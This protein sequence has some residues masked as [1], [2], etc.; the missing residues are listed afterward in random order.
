MLNVPTTTQ[1][2]LLNRNV[3]VG[4]LLSEMPSDAILRGF[5]KN[6]YRIL[7]EFYLKNSPTVNSRLSTKRELLDCMNESN[8]LRERR[9]EASVAIG[10]RDYRNRVKQGVSGQSPCPVNMRLT[11]RNT[12]FAR[13]RQNSSQSYESAALTD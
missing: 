1:L 3:T 12:A 6:S 13:N 5:F 7:Q 4:N 11:L 8:E 9:G 2:E 10:S